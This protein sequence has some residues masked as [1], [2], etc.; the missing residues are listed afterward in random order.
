MA[1]VFEK[2]GKLDRSLKFYERSLEIYKTNLGE[3]HML[4]ADILND[5]AYALK[6]QGS[7]NKAKA[8]ILKSLKIKKRLLA[9][10]TVEAGIRKKLVD[11]MI[12]E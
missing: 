10:R 4:V 7:P 8:F 11:R 12:R 1:L 2:Q 6:E 9:E 5:M 3:K